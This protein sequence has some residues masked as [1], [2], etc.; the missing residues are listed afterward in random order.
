M[1]KIRYA[2]GV[3]GSNL[4]FGLSERSI[5]KSNPWIVMVS[6]P[7]AREGLFERIEKEPKNTCLYKRLFL[8]Y[9]YGLSKIYT[10]DETTA[11]KA[12]S[13]FEREY[14]PKYLLS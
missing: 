14:N 12:S 3:R 10:E 1:L 2:F 9:T 8:D 13:S 11:A 5:A 7:N 6:T 4:Y